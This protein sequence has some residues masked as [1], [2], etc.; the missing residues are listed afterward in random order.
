MARALFA[1][2]CVMIVAGAAAAQTS[3]EG[4]WTAGPTRVE[5][6]IESWGPDCGPRPTSTT[7]PAAGPVRVTTDGDQL[8]FHGRREQRT[9]GCWSENRAVRRVS[10]SREA[11][12]WTV[13]C[14][15]PPNDPRGETGTYV[16]S[17]DGDNRLAF[18]DDSHYDW[19]LNESRCRGSIVAT[20][21]FTRATVAPTPT[22]EPTPE[23]PRCTAGEPAALHL[24]PATSQIEPGESVRFTAR[25]VDRA[26]CPV[27]TARVQWEL[28]RP[29]SVQGELS[30]GL[31]QAAGSA[32]DGEGVFRVVARS[33][34]LRAEAS[35]EVRTADLS[36][37]IAR[38]T[39]A[40]VVQADDSEVELEAATGVSARGEPAESRGVAPWI[41]AAVAALGSIVV[42]ALVVMLFRRRKP[43]LA[44]SAPPPDADDGPVLAS[45][46]EPE[47][48]GVPRVAASAPP[49][50]SAPPS[51][52]IPLRQKLLVPRVCPVCDREFDDPGV[53]FCPEDG[54]KLI[55]TKE[56][57]QTGQPLICP[58]CRRGFPAGSKQCPTDGDELVPYALFVAKKREEAAGGTRICPVCGSRYGRDVAF[59]GR[60][61][62]E[63]V[64]VN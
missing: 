59:C 36:D 12:R 21:T 31:F 24:R 3:Y 40:G 30:G 10:S 26:G 43:R 64:L 14:R 58:T 51:P 29:A 6:Q 34:S 28:L 54:A 35:V 37:F 33:G 39:S 7:V 57:S 17:A 47:R 16:L 44:Q 4:T 46:P 15:T 23:H 22:P 1:F 11:G 32:A 45:E 25:V 52:A 56:A 55:D 5:V 2:G 9:D 38:R 63:L 48:E 42:L 60:D 18:R 49:S 41:L 8:V 62:S 19:Q 13:I 53:G 27:S 50:E 61:G 20:Q